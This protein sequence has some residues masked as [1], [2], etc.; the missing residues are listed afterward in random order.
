MFERYGDPKYGINHGREIA[1]KNGGPVGSRPSVRDKIRSTV[2]ERYGY[3][4]IW[5]VPEVI[6]KTQEKI[7]NANIEKY[8]VPCVMQVIEIVAKTRKK[9]LFD[10][11]YFDSSW[12]LAYFIWLRDNKIKFEYHTRSLKYI[13]NGKEH[14]Y[15][16]DFIVEGR[17]V[18]I[19]GSHLFN[20]GKLVDFYHQGFSKEQLDEKTKCMLNNNVLLITDVTKQLKY[21][22]YKYGRNYM[23]RFK[24]KEK[25]RV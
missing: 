7:K 8:G 3:D 9:Y 18:E 1:L 14:Y 17:Y 20:N 4:H 21:V 16:P 15:F 5:K 25:L 23:K 11:I 10:G 19:K 2:K 24:I 22:T 13:V 6:K 12:E